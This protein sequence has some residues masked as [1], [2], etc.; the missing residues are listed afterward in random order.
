[1]FFR[2]R[3]IVCSALLLASTLG[4]S[5]MSG[6]SAIEPRTASPLCL[7]YKN[8]PRLKALCG[9]YSQDVVKVVHELPEA[10]KMT[11]DALYILDNT[12]PEV[13]VPYVI[14]K[15]TAVIPHPG[16]V[17]NEQLFPMVF[18]PSGTGSNGQCSYC[19]FILS[20]G[21][22]LAG[23]TLD[24]SGV[25]V[26][27]KDPDKFSTLIYGETRVSEASQLFL[28]G[29]SQLNSLIRQ[30]VVADQD[31]ETFQVYSTLAMV[32]NGAG[33]G[34]LLENSSGKRIDPGSENETAWDVKIS[35]VVADMNGPVAKGVHWSRAIGVGNIRPKIGHSTILFGK[36][37]NNPDFGRYGIHLDEVPRASLYSINPG[38][39]WSDQKR[40]LDLGVFV[41]G[42]QRTTLYIS[43][44]SEGLV[45]SGMTPET[46][47]IIKGNPLTGSELIDRVDMQQLLALSRNPGSVTLPLA[48]FED[49]ARRYNQNNY[50]LSEPLFPVRN[51]SF[52]V[53][54][55]TVIDP[56]D[57][58]SYERCA[59]GHESD[60]PWRTALIAGNVIMGVGLVGTVLVC[61]I[62]LCVRN[63]Q[64]LKPNYEA[65]N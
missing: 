15:G 34:L 24:A 44:V 18:Q 41:E 45:T 7:Q 21:A 33:N 5:S 48:A 53:S 49:Y 47:F 57:P 38:W 6:S 12:R 63:H 61:G 9:L 22:R 59:S 14:P 32:L 42:E 29:N 56:A 2:K 10:D 62:A 20:E 30:K 25:Q 31:I 40:P 43:P 4:F 58:A 50:S 13:T 17:T 37:A 8:S 3:S 65:I 64:R 26:I 60:N 11:A 35:G 36:I 55:A 28:R 1:M 19:M 39:G 51:N 27:D 52:Q 46:L 16:L 23:A 54:H